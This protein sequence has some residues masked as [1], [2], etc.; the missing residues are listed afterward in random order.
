MSYLN[1]DDNIYKVGTFIQAKEAPFVR[2]E[3]KKYS[4]RVYY[5]AV[6]GNEAAKQKVY[7]EREL[8]APEGPAHASLR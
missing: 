5:C 6:V 4:H 3:I 1:N 7:F 2:L 8:I